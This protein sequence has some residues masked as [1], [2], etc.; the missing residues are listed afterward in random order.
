MIKTMIL[1]TCQTYLVATSLAF[2]AEAPLRFQCEWQSRSDLNSA[3]QEDIA[4]SIVFAYQPTG[5][6]VG[7]LTGEGLGTKFEATHIDRTIMAQVS[8]EADGADIYERLEI[9][10]MTGSIKNWYESGTEALLLE[11]RCTKLD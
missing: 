11:G 9:N 1:P 10:S 2:A 7:V 5:E 8:Y 3:Q 6:G 4:G